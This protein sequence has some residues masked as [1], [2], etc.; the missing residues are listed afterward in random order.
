MAENLALR[1]AAARGGRAKEQADALLEALKAERE[2]NTAATQQA[3]KA[4]EEAA[5]AQQRVRS[6]RLTSTSTL[7][8]A[9][10]YSHRHIH[11]H[12]RAS[13]RAMRQALG[14]LL[15]HEL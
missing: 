4:R 1:E 15:A 14:S 9:F 7:T 6:L 5:R 11:D 13:K 12:C 10:I 8:F 2:H 3:A